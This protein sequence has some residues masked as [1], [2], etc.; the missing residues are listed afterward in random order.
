M[1]YKVSAVLVLLL[2]TVGTPSPHSSQ[3]HLAPS[4]EVIG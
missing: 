2:T 4:E 1:E 3:P